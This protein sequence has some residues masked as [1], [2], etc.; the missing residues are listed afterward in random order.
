LGIEYDIEQK[1]Y[2]DLLTKKSSA[3]LTAT[4][5]NMSEGERMFPLNPANLP[6]S[7]D[8]PN[9]FLFSA[10]GLGSGLGLGVALLLWTKR[11]KVIQK[12]IQADGEP[13]SLP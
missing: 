7:P 4:M 3:N 9:R 2:Q 1:V 13:I 11:R 5:M 8:S 6:D 12:V 10:S